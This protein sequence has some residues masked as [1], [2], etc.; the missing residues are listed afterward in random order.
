[1]PCH[2]SMKYNKLW[3]S[4][5]KDRAAFT[6]VEIMVA[7]GM[8]ALTAAAAIGTLIR[9]NN[10]AALARLQTGAT[11][12]AQERIDH[13]LADEPFDVLK[14]QIP[15]VLTLG[16]KTIGTPSNPTIPIYTDPITNQVIVYG[17]MTST[18]NKT[19][20]A[21]GP[22]VVE[23]R[24]ADVVVGYQFRGKPYTV[25]MCTVRSPDA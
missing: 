3:L 23:V 21:Y 14:N 25:R 7:C 18:V 1:V 16:T 19:T 10:N 22:W 11:T 4:R 2:P 20:Q 15:D 17:W 6:I 8:L 9:L 12:V 24:N 5:S 13:I